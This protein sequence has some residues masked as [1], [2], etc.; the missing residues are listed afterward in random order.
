[1][2]FLYMIGHAYADLYVGVAEEPEQRVQYHN[3]RRGALYTKRDSKFEIVF[4]EKY[5]ELAEA[6]KREIQI[7][8]WGRKKKDALMAR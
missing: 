2:Y 1:M 3:E 6:R 5:P 7:E 4:L 8:K